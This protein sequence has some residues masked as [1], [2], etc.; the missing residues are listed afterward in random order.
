MEYGAFANNPN[1]RR[2]TMKVSQ[3]IDFHLQY[4]RHQNL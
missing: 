2:Y 3:A 4:H 1:D